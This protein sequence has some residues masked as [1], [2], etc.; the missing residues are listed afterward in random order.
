MSSNYGI[1][2]QYLI[3]IL[4]ITLLSMYILQLLSILAWKGL[5]QHKNLSLFFYK[6]FIFKLL[7]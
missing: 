1:G 6:P 3:M 2:E 4:F 5:V 7:Y